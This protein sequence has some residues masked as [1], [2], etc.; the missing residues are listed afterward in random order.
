MYNCKKMTV[1]VVRDGA[2]RVEKEYADYEV[3]GEGSGRGSGRALL[4][5]T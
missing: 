5:A 1:D 4:P 3:S 2:G